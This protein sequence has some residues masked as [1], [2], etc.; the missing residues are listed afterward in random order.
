MSETYEFPRIFG[1]SHAM[2][3]GYSRLESGESEVYRWLSSISQ[4]LNLQRLAAEF[5]RKGFQTKHS[6][7]LQYIAKNDL[8]IMNDLDIKLEV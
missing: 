1:V 6:R 4:G 3:N 7:S 2:Q 8:D 5:E